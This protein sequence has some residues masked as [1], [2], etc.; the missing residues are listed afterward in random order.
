MVEEDKRAMGYR[1]VSARKLNKELE[2]REKG[3]EFLKD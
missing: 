1:D 2:L 3:R